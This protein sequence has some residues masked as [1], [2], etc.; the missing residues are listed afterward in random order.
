MSKLS[1]KC[2]S[3]CIHG[4]NQYAVSENEVRRMIE[5]VKAECIDAVND[6]Y[7]LPEMASI[8]VDNARLHEMYQSIAIKAIKAVS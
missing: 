5:A 6:A 4:C 8:T 3:K 2:Q 7:K 1:D